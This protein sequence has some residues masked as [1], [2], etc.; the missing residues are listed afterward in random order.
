M[1]GNCCCARA[2]RVGRITVQQQLR[3][4][5][6]YDRETAVHHFL[7]SKW[8]AWRLKLDCVP[9]IMFIVR[10]CASTY[11]Y[12]RCV[13]VLAQFVGLAYMW[14]A[15]D[16]LRACSWT[17]GHAHKSYCMRKYFAGYNFCGVAQA[18][19]NRENV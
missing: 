16:G 19:E 15:I 7:S 12:R 11:I 5:M 17:N 13:L 14:Y 9:T 1:P 6:Q 18:C 2:H 4:I 8:S 3:K 10:V